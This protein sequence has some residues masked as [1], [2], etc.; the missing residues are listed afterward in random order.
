MCKT[1]KRISSK[2]EENIANAVDYKELNS[3][4]K[5]IVKDGMCSFTCVQFLHDIIDSF[6][7]DEV[8]LNNM[9]NNFL[10]KYKNIESPADKDS[11]KDGKE[12]NNETLEYAHKWIAYKKSVDVYEGIPGADKTAIKRL[13][14]MIDII[15]YIDVEFYTIAKVKV[16]QGNEEYEINNIISML[17]EKGSHL[18]FLFNFKHKEI[19][20][21]NEE[22]K[23]RSHA[24]I[25]LNVNGKVY[26][27]DPADGIVTH[28]ISND[29]T[30]PL[31]YIFG[32]YAP[33]YAF[34]LVKMQKKQVPADDGL[35]ITTPVA[36][37]ESVEISSEEDHSCSKKGCCLLI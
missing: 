27:F 1:F 18:L 22:M 30:A 9:W 2:K 15:P 37:L 7:Q 34:E 10:H 31:R 20:N 8:E 23:N 17:K 33:I 19:V 32:R 3:R 25:Y 26:V 36:D 16:S 13:N 11:D 12:I 14:R 4:M 21:G 6:P 24:V 29:F 35:S 28:N 5:Q